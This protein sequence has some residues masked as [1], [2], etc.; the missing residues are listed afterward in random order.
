[1]EEIF[2]A[3]RFFSEITNIYIYIYLIIKKQDDYWF[4]VTKQKEGEEEQEILIRYQKKSD[5]D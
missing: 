3:D 2:G 4:I 5:K 1:M